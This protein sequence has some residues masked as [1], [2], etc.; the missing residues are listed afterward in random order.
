QGRSSKKDGEVKCYTCGEKGH[1]AAQCPK[2]GF[3][4]SSIVTMP[5]KV[6][7]K[8]YQCGKEGHIRP[9]CPERSK[10]SHAVSSTTND[11]TVM[12]VD[13]TKSSDGSK[14]TKT[15]TVNGVTCTAFV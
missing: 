6:S 10:S 8:C 9:D 4:S 15:I 5:K 7:L 3:R 11:S 2:S 14:Y 12:L 1:I 13:S